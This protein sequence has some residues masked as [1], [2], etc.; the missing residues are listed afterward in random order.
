[1]LLI[2]QRNLLSSGGTRSSVPPGPQGEVG[3]A[4]MPVNLAALVGRLHRPFLTQGPILPGG[5]GFLFHRELNVVQGLP[6]LGERP[7]VL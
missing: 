6:R 7:N 4:T 3:D 5:E 2:A 1:M